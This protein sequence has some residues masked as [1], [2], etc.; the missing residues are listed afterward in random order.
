MQN[1]PLHDCKVNTSA[2]S[3]KYWKFLECMTYETGYFLIIILF[4]I[5]ACFL[6]IGFND[7]LRLQLLI[8]KIN[9]EASCNNSSFMT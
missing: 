1:S 4:I 5:N 3:I 9:K 7:C 8:I 6:H 2:F